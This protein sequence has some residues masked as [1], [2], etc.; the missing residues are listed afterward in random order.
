MLKYFLPLKYSYIYELLLKLSFRKIVFWNNFQI[1]KKH[2]EV[3]WLCTNNKN[4]VQFLNMPQ[5]VIWTEHSDCVWV[6]I[7]ISLWKSTWR[8]HLWS[9]AHWVLHIHKRVPGMQKVRQEVVLVSTGLSL[10]TA[11]DFCRPVFAVKIE[12]ADGEETWRCPE[13]LRYSWIIEADRWL[14]CC[15]RRSWV[16]TKI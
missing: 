11:E 3:C 9:A 10:W 8:P 15:H 12:L 14:A 13:F 7:I 16:S 2:T 6:N 1:K 4:C 5:H